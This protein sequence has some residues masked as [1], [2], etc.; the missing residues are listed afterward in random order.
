MTD[1]NV[2]APEWEPGTP[3]GLRGARVG[4]AAGAGELGATVYELEP[5]AAV[6]PYHLHHANE[7]LLVVLSG[8]PAVRTPDGVRRLEPGAV[9]AFPAG[10]DGAHRVSNPD[11]DPARVLLVST[12]RYPDVC[13]HLST[14]ATLVMPEPGAG[15]LFRDEAPFMEAYTAAMEF[16]AAEDQRG[17]STS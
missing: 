11:G 13:E 6:S 5:G 16:D 4:A 1:P 15:K 12:M 8:R 2:F 3:P 7:E 10:Q 14:G 9:V 17:L